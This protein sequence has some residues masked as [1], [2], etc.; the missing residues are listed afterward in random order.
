MQ[1]CLTFMSA[2]PKATLLVM[3]YLA[4]M[5]GGTAG[6]VGSLSSLHLESGYCL[7][8]QTML[9]TIFLMTSQGIFSL[10]SALITSL[11]NRL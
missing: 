2:R 11:S 5:Y 8:I 6:L 3:W 1:I 7:P 9:A 10:S 4:M